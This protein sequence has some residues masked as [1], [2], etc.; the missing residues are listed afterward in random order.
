MQTE[1]QKPKEEPVE[2]EWTGRGLSPKQQELKQKLQRKKDKDYNKKLP[3]AEQTQLDE[4]LAVEKAEHDRQAAIHRLSSAAD[5]YGRKE[6]ARIRREVTDRVKKLDQEEKTEVAGVQKIYQK[7]RAEME[8]EMKAAMRRVQ[9]Q[10]NKAMA[11][12][13]AEEEKDLAEVRTRYKSGYD[14]AS[15]EINAGVDSV[16]QE[17]AGF[18]A[19]IQELELEQ[20]QKLQTDGILQN[21]SR[22]SATFIVVPGTPDKKP[23]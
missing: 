5:T 1:E 17:V 2:E 10:H 16:T 21:G 8:R 19:D 22:K 6:V 14:Q 20:L 9:E 12:L 18:V 11:E 3:K 15:D 13:K 7:G 4:L 23:A